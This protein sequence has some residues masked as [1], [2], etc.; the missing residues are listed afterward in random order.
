MLTDAA[1][2]CKPVSGHLQSPCTQQNHHTTSHYY[3]FVSIANLLFF[4]G[5]AQVRV[6]IHHKKSQPPTLKKQPPLKHKGTY[7]SSNANLKLDECT[8]ET[9][10]CSRSEKLHLY[11]KAIKYQP[12]PQANS[13]APSHPRPHT[14][15]QFGVLF[16][17][18][19]LRKRMGS[20]GFCSQKKKEKKE[21]FSMAIQS[22]PV[23]KSPLNLKKV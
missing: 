14:H 6:F 7:V 10:M 5:S 20:Q 18:N 12:A 8:F 2:G 9:L 13:S 17:K 4:T 3:L 21:A 23:D 1:S 22:Q 15:T 11:S 16:D 19:P